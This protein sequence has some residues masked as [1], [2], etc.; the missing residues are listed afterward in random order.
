M[1]TNEQQ[2]PQPGADSVWPP[3]MFHTRS[4]GRS[5]PVPPSFRCRSQ[6]L[7][8]IRNQFIKVMKEGADH[9]NPEEE[10]DWD[11]AQMSAAQLATLGKLFLDMAEWKLSYGS[12]TQGVT[13][14]NQDGAGH[15]GDEFPGCNSVSEFPAAPKMPT[16][17]H[18]GGGKL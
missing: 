9:V 15:S 16:L 8:E 12:E 11:M 6:A 17:A 2:H 10:F 4:A 18:V 14:G 13:R 1:L 5:T 3:T 7:Q